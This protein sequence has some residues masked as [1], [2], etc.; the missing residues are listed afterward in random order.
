MTEEFQVL[1][2]QINPLKIGLPCLQ[3]YSAFFIQ[4][5]MWCTEYSSTPFFSKNIFYHIVN[6][7]FLLKKE[8]LNFCKFDIVD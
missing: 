5:T 4:F 1:I 8:I 7:Y 2:H 6:P 3:A